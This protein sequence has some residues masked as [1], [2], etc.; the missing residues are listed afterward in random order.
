M[1]TKAQLKASKAC[2][3]ALNGLEYKE[4]M[5]IIVAIFR[6]LTRNRGLSNEDAGK[7]MKDALDHLDRFKENR[8]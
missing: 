6:E 4:G 1:P 3:D 5:A 2:A 8:P 7:F